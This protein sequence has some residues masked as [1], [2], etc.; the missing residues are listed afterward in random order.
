MLLALASPGAA[1]ADGPMV[2]AAPVISGNAVVGTTLHA[3]TGSWIADQPV[4]AAYQWLRCDPNGLA[5]GAIHGAGSLDYL[6]GGRDVG[7][8]LRVLLIATLDGAATNGEGDG[9]DVFAADLVARAIAAS[10]PT[11]VVSARAAALPA[12]AS[13][14]PPHQ[15]PDHPHPTHKHKPKPD[16]TPATPTGGSDPAPH[17]TPAPAPALRRLDP[18]PIVRIRGRLV[19][20][21]ALVTLFSV[22][23]QSGV[24]IDVRCA[25]SGC[26]TPYVSILA[27]RSATRLR[28][29]EGFL[30]AGLRLTVTVTAPGLIGKYTSLRIRTGRAPLRSD[31][32]LMP[33]GTRPVRCPA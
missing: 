17:P 30:R 26:P 10:A 27:T 11:A 4:T 24:R 28:P 32:C 22:R 13:D 12:P 1:Q 6:I 19:R 16:E 25:G 15:H 14:P 9:G 2:T 18:F 8:R 5:C 3:T 33:G 7:S 20:R 31:R 29:Y 23:A 21:G